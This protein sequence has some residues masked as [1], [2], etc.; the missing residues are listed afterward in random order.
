MASMGQITTCFGFII[1]LPRY[2]DLILT[3]VHMQR[4]I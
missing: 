2:A 1:S 4:I 3:E